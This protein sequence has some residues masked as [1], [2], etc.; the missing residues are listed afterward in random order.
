MFQ[1]RFVNARARASNAESILVKKL[2][3]NEG[4]YFALSTLELDRQTLN[5]F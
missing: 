4:F 2:V 5:Q 3:K 1:L